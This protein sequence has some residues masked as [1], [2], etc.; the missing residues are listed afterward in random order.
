MTFEE[1]VAAID[2]NLLRRDIPEFTKIVKSRIERDGFFTP[3][4][5][6]PQM[7]SDYPEVWEIRKKMTPEHYANIDNWTEKDFIDNW[8]AWM[9]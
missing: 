2:M 3:S 4:W 6:T 5:N 9:I 8:I 1:A 7:N